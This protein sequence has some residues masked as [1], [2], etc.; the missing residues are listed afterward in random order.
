MKSIL[1]ILALVLTF[2]TMASEL[3]RGIVSDER[4]QLTT[5]N[6]SDRIVF[7]LIT[8]N[9]YNNSCML[10]AKSIKI[11]KGS[12]N[13]AGLIEIQTEINFR[14]CL[15]TVGKHYGEI[16]LIKGQYLPSLPNGSYEIIIDGESYGYLKL[17][18]RGFE[19]GNG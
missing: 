2:N 17:S 3:G 1:L 12:R 14:S 5:L 7:A 10:D 15:M 8:T 6:F 16:E 9:E 4:F 18:G 19:I 13:E 11:E